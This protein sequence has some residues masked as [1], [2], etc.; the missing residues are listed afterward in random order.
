MTD[1][2]GANNSMGV[3][4]PLVLPDAPTEF[5][6]ALLDKDLVL[7]QTLRA[8]DSDVPLPLLLITAYE[9][10]RSV[11]ERRTSGVVRAACAGLLH[12][13]NARSGGPLG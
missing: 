9:L 12:V 10:S 4:C 3:P 6:H 11:P 8:N 7:W 13:P 1:P 5:D 2:G